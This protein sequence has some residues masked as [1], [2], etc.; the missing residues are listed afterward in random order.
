[1]GLKGFQAKYELSHTANL[2]KAFGA[3]DS[4]IGCLKEHSK[5][6]KH[7]WIN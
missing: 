5:T 1:L 2:S 3:Y 6:A 7:I 4:F